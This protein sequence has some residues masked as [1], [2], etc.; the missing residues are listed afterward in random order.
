MQAANRVLF[1]HTHTHI[2][3]IITH[4]QYSNI[5]IDCSVPVQTAKRKVQRVEVVEI[6][7]EEVMDVMDSDALYLCV[8]H[9]SEHRAHAWI[10]LLY[11][12][13]HIRIRRV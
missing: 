13:I 9:I 2:V 6:I 4:T 7:V 1:T 3:Y 12:Y 8:W 11:T 10:V 5:L